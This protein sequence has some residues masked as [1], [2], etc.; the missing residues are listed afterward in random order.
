MPGETDNLTDLEQ[1]NEEI[2]LLEL[3]KR[4]ENVPSWFRNKGGGGR[5]PVETVIR[6][7]WTIWYFGTPTLSLLPGTIT[8]SCR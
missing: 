8:S 7:A 5:C 3:N 1:L 6:A 4:Y 2:L